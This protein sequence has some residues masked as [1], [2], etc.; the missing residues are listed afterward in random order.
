[1]PNSVFYVWLVV[2][3]AAA[4]A[5]G[6]GVA[7]VLLQR[8]QSDGSHTLELKAQQA[9]LEAESQAKEK[10]LEAK[11]EAVKVRT[12]LTTPTSRCPQSC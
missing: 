2:V 5:G 4:L 11:E 7:F 9:L 1:M 8:R 6:F 10:L 3:A 12:P